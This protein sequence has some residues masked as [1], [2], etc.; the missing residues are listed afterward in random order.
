MNVFVYN[1][2]GELLKETAGLL[3]GSSSQYIWLNGSVVG[4]IR[5]RDLYAV[6]ND[7]LG[8]PEAVTDDAR[9]VVWKAEN[10]AFDRKVVRDAF[11]GLNLGFPGQYH[12]EESGLWYNGHRYYDASIGRYLQSDPI[13]LAG[14]INTYAYASANPLS[15]TDSTGLKCDCSKSAGENFVDS[16]VDNRNATKDALSSW[17]GKA[18]SFGTGAVIGKSKAA[19]A[20]TGTETATRA[21]RSLPAGNPFYGSAIG[22]VYSVGLNFAVGFAITF[23]GTEAGVSVGSLAVAGGD[24]LSNTLFCP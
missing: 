14:G 2:Q 7:H 18:F 6:H 9:Q 4:I 16:Y 23:A 21:L 20:A 24:A 3:G 10:Y 8:R 19:A 11:G 13:G 17:T 12:D 15:L 1:P 5:G 22:T